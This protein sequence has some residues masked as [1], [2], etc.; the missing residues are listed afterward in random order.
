MVFA[1]KMGW[2]YRHELKTCL[3]DP[4]QQIKSLE[5]LKGSELKANGIKAVVLDFDGV[6]AA[7]GETRPKKKLEAWLEGCMSL[8]GADHVFILT[9]K[10]EKLRRD[11]C[12]SRFPGIVFVQ[13]RKKPYPDGLNAI[14]EKEKIS[15]KELVMVDDRLLT[16]ILA[17]VLVGAK[18]ILVT[19][20]FKDFTKRPLPELGFSLL[21]TLERWI[22]PLL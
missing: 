19:K 22:I 9:N 7:Y 3:K 4:T 12:L 15:P 10:P 13:S 6:L 2:R 14:L 18:P 11:Y 21:R 20:P 16:G 17:A 8:F 1:L 5:D